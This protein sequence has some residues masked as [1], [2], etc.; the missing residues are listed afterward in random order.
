MTGTAKPTVF[1]DNDRVVVEMPRRSK[2]LV[3]V[4]SPWSVIRR[5][6]SPHPR[7][8]DIG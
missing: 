3:D 6:L 5:P 2:F 1:I 8:T 4:S 7:H